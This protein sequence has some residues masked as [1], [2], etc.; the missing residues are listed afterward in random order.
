MRFGERDSAL[1]SACGSEGNG[2]PTRPTNSLRRSTRWRR[3]RD[4]TLFELD[5]RPLFDGQFGA[6]LEEADRGQFEVFFGAGGEACDAFTSNLYISP[7][8]TRS[9]SITRHDQ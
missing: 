2:S 3:D 9:E 1:K 7:R 4:A 6:T 5:V 8:E